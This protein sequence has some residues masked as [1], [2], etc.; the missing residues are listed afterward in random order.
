MIRLFGSSNEL[1]VY[2][3]VLRSCLQVKVIRLSPTLVV[4]VIAQ[5]GIQN[6]NTSR[7]TILLASIQSTIAKLTEP[8][9]LG[10]T[11][12][13]TQPNLSIFSFDWCII[14]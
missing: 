4:P 6:P 7:I 8:T 2:L 11:K 12:C 5:Q 9:T 10:T 14:G 3:I 13:T 1:Q